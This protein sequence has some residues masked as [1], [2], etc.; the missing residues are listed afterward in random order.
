VAVQDISI[1]NRMKAASPGT[2]ISSP[3]GKQKY[4]IPTL[5]GIEQ[6]LQL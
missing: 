4:R 3:D 6:I 1:A 2:A 5:S